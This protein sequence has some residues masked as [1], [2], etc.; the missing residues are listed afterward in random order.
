MISIGKAPVAERESLNGATLHQE[1]DA[2]HRSRRAEVFR[3]LVHHKGAM[4]GFVILFILVLTALLAPVIATHDPI[5][6]SSD[7]LQSP[8]GAHLMGTDNFGRDIF[9]R[10]V[11]GA[12]ISLQM[13]IVAVL[14]GTTAGT[15]IGLVAGH[16]GGLTDTLLMRV[17]DALMAFPGILLALTIA[18]VL[19][20]GIFNAMIAV[21]I[22]WIPQFARLVRGNVLQVNAMPYVEAARS[23]G[24]SNRRLIV[25]HVFPNVTTPIL[26]LSTLGIASAILIGASLSFLGLGAQPPTAE[27]GAI[28][29]QGRQYMRHAWWMMTFPGIAITITVMSANLLGDGLRDALDPRMKI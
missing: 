20:T 7:N 4:S 27:W 9:S 3:R 1:G 13:G 26:V 28:L 8:S 21:G 19:G 24:A 10:V 14:I 16:Y 11:F 5:E 15:V 6:V 29:N 12:R 23:M 22:S 25:R 17:I 18:A 2:R